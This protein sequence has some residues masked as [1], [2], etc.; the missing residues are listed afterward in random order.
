MK[1][2]KFFES[3]EKGYI[4]IL[5][6]FTDEGGRL[7]VELKINKFIKNK[8]RREICFQREVEMVLAKYYIGCGKSVPVFQWYLC[9]CPELKNEFNRISHEL[10]G[11]L[12]VEP[13]W[14]YPFM[15]LC[16]RQI[17]ELVDKWWDER[18]FKVDGEWKYVV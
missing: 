14:K 2:R 11:W 1:I 17:K 7:K 9:E 4:E 13:C 10:L 15:N 8:F 12:S 18:G 16:D 3:Y 5:N 6:V